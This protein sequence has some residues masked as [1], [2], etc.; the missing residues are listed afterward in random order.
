MLP[1]KVTKNGDPFALP[2]PKPVFDL[3]YKAEIDVADGQ[4]VF[5]LSTTDK[6]FSGHSAP[7]KRVRVAS[8][9]A[10]FNFHDLRGTFL[11]TLAELGVGDATVADALLNHRQSAI[12]AGVLAAYNHASL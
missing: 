8:G 6:P 9:V 3:M 10:D 7:A 4:S 5:S 11:T 2:M 12:R 1:G